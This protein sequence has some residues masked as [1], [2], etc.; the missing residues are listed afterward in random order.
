VITPHRHE[1]TVACSGDYEKIH[2]PG[3]TWAGLAG[4][5]EPA[6]KRGNRDIPIVRFKGFTSSPNVR[7]VM[8]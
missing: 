8:R 2:K 3:G 7:N 5:G 4:T 1:A 6:S